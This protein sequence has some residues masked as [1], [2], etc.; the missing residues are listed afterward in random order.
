MATSLPGRPRQRLG[1]T[2]TFP[3]D[4]LRLKFRKVGKVDPRVPDTTFIFPKLVGYFGG[5][6]ITGTGGVKTSAVNMMTF[7]TDTR[8]SPA[9]T[10]SSARSGISG[11]GNNQKTYMAGGNTTGPTLVETVDVIVQSSSTRSTPASAGFGV[12]IQYA[13][14]A[15]SEYTTIFQTDSGTRASGSYVGYRWVVETDTIASAG[16]QPGNSRKAGAAGYMNPGF[17]ASYHAGGSGDASASS[18]T[19]QIQK[20]VAATNVWSVI[21]QALTQSRWRIAGLSGQLY[22]LAAGGWINSGSGRVSRVDYLHFNTETGGATFSLPDELRQGAAMSSLDHGYL[23]G[24]GNSNP[25]ETVYKM[26][27]PALTWAAVTTM[28]YGP[29]GCGGG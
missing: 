29:E 11:G 21:T 2:D 16:T 22:G 9:V 6:V 24:D 17:T 10:L 13:S 15:S 28:S 5:G 20:L 8:S 3:L 4:S 14:V 27:W 12:G 26:V 23:V 19:T 18:T 25:K 7:A 1:G